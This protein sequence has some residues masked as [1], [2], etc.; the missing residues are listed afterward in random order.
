MAL[1]YYEYVLYGNNQIAINSASYI[2]RPGSTVFYYESANYVSPTIYLEV[3]LKNVNN[4]VNKSTVKLQE[5]ASG[6]IANTAGSDVTSGAVTASTTTM[7]VYRTA[8]LT[9]TD[10]YRYK[11][12]NIQ[13][14]AS[15]TVVLSYAKIVIIDDVGTSTP[16]AVSPSLI[17]TWTRRLLLAIARPTATDNPIPR[18]PVEQ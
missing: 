14:S 10:G 9:L 16:S 13:Q 1:I 18:L 3:G 2:D 5:F 7:A 8:A 6:D 17:I 11:I 4:S 15:T 12:Q